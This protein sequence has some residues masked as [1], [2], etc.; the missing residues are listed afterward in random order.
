V[1]FLNSTLLARIARRTNSALEGKGRDCRLLC[2][3]I[4]ATFSSSSRERRGALI[5]S[6]ST[7][8]FIISEC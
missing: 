7:E 2:I 5:Y 3:N 4:Y 6:D 8:K 1:N